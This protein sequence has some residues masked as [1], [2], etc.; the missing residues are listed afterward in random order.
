V[1]RAIDPHFALEDMIARWS[2]VSK[3]LAEN[4]RKRKSQL[5]QYYYYSEVL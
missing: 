3:L 5:S 4:Q 1:K 2:D